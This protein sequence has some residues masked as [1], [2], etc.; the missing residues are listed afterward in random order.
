MLKNDIKS[1][2]PKCSSAFML[3]IIYIIIM[4]T[5]MM[6]MNLMTNKQEQT[7]QNLKW[8]TDIDKTNYSFANTSNE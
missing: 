6:K 7:T 1:Y 4:F 5:L 3:Y 8:N 2:Q